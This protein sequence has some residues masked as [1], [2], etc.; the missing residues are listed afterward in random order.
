MHDPDTP[1]GR[2][3]VAHETVGY[4]GG[5]EG[6]QWRREMEID[7]TVRGSSLVFTDWRERAEH[8]VIDPKSIPDHWV[9]HMGYDYGYR[10]PFS[11]I[12]VAYNGRFEAYVVDEIYEKGLPI[13][14][15][16]RLIKQSPFWERTRF[17]VGDPSIWHK[18]QHV[19]NRV[20]STGD[21]LSGYGIH[22]QRGRKEPG[23]DVAFRDMLLSSY[24]KN[25]T[26]PRLRIFRTC[27]NLIRELSRLKFR[28][29]IT[30]VAAERSDLM[31]EIA[32][33]K[34]HAWDC[35]KYI[36]MHYPI[37]EPDDLPAPEGTLE[38]VRR[39]IKK[40]RRRQ[41]YLLQ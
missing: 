27:P 30:R 3:W 2:E 14:E 20:M 17:K 12:W 1:D 7:F 19:G 23:V 39:Q 22:L 26:N 37:V 34:T 21:I 18:T 25:K 4:P 8:C 36:M 31:E 9:V 6:T 11:A 41:K 15:Q 33:K 32:S 28:D 29:Y 13:Q 5:I 35:L 24:W 16:A 40:M 38:A 10:E